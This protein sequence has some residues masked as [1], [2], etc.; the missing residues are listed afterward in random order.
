MKFSPLSI[1]TMVAPFLEG[2]P[3]HE[4]TQQAQAV[5]QSV[6]SAAPTPATTDQAAEIALLKCQVAALMQSI[7]LMVAARKAGGG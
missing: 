1:L 4:H 2:D 6:V 7:H 3:T 5:V